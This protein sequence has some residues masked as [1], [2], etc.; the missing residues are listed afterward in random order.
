MNTVRFE[1]N[2][3]H[4]TIGSRPPVMEIGDG[5]TVITSI[6]D[7]HGL[8]A[9]ERPVAPRGN[10]MTGPFF[11]RDAEPGDCLEVS[12][13]QIRPNREFGWSRSTI[14]PGVLDPDFVG[15]VVGTGTAQYARWRVDVKQRNVTLADPV[16]TSIGA[17]TVAMRPMI[18][19]FGVAPAF[20]QAISTATSA[21]HGGNMDYRGFTEG[22]I[23]RFPIF[24]PGALFFLGD[25]HAAQGDGEIA[26]TGVEISCDVT[27]GV[28]LRKNVPM[29]WPGGE[30][31]THLFTVG[32]ARPL[33]QA[34]QH[35]TTEM[36]FLL[37][38]AY[39]LDE[40]GAAILLG[41]SVE[42]DIANVF[43]PAYTVVCKVRKELL[44]SPPPQPG[45]TRT[46]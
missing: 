5:D 2:T 22:V 43:D 7:A 37:G 21:E 4:L 12:I 20:G 25:G 9:N 17:H 40:R 30:N 28:R 18:G 15:N 32:N 3:Y 11:I 31:A 8:D 14:A 1:P 13:E 27:F 46:S 42:Y 24:V 34:L 16:D 33:D 23:A 29:R 10:P 26:G 38:S 19:C 36:L 6:V 35:A 45:Y 41:Q 39:G 44:P